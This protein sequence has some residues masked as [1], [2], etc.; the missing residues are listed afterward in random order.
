MLTT[1]FSWK[2]EFTPK[3]KW[4]GGRVV[5]THTH[6]QGGGGGGGV[7][8]QT[9]TQSGEAKVELAGVM[10]GMGY[11]LV[12]SKEMPLVIRQHRRLYELIG[13]WATVWKSEK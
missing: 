5:E 9:H 6:T 4:L 2:E 8:T 7:D 3:E 12:D 1:P 13:A 11:V 10:E